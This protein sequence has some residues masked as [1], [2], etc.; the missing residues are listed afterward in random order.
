MA[1]FI[2][3]EQQTAVVERVVSRFERLAIK[4]ELQRP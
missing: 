1:A 3:L 2:F 4:R